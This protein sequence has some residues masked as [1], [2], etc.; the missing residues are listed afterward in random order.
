MGVT[1]PASNDA[2]IATVALEGISVSSDTP[3]EK[4]ILFKKRHQAELG[5]FRSALDTLA[6][7]LQEDY[8]S[9]AALE[10][11][12]VDI[13]RNSVQPAVAT[14]ERSMGALAIQAKLDMVSVATFSAPATLLATLPTTSS[15]ELA[16]LAGGSIAL[17]VQAAKSRAAKHEQLRTNPYSYL[18]SIR[19]EF[20]RRRFVRGS[21]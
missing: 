3:I 10:Q 9:Q 5:A 2:L 21:S 18:L 15:K 14:L 16:I 20:A 11:V 8:P 1:Q 17:I 12:I 19:N 13:Y 7:S 4:V 6:K